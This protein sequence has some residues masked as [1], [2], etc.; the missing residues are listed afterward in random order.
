MRR[1]PP[2]FLAFAFCGPLMTSVVCSLPIDTRSGQ[3]VP[4]IESDFSDEIPGLA[5]TFPSLIAGRWSAMVGPHPSPVLITR[6]LLKLGGPCPEL[7]R[8][9]GRRVDH[10]KNTVNVVTLEITSS[11]GCKKFLSYAVIAYSQDE[12]TDDKLSSLWWIGCDSLKQLRLFE[13][14]PT[15]ACSSYALIR[16]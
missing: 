14:H 5:A 9:V 13:Q 7:Y 8:V 1:W 4:G 15:Q 6:K 2:V 11:A 10:Q 12:V 3:N 16:E